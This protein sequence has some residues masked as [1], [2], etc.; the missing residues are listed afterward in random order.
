[1]LK[2]LLFVCTVLEY[3]KL[4]IEAIMHM[5]TIGELFNEIVSSKQASNLVLVVYHV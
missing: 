4:Q 1:M 5:F 2:I 3:Q